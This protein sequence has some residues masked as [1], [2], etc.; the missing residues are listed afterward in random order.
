MFP[1]GTV[2]IPLD[3]PCRSARIEIVDP[4]PG[5]RYRLELGTKVTAGEGQNGFVVTRPDPCAPGDSRRSRTPLTLRFAWGGARSWGEVGGL[6]DDRLE[7]AA[8]VSTGLEERVRAI[9]AGRA[10]STGHR[11]D[12]LLEFVNR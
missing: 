9:L 3:E 1:E 4:P 8:R 11:I 7:R 2:Q 5:F 12:L 6:Y 10:D